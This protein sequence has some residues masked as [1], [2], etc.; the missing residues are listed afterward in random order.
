M[1]KTPL[2][3][4][5][6]FLYALAEYRQ[7]G[8]TSKVVKIVLETYKIKDNREIILETEVPLTHTNEGSSK[9]YFLPD[10]Y[11]MDMF[12][13]NSSASFACN[14]MHCVIYSNQYICFFDQYSG[15][16]LLK[17]NVGNHIST[18]VPEENLFYRLDIA[19]YGTLAKCSVKNFKPKDLGAKK[20]YLPNPPILL[21][22]AKGNFIKQQKERDAS[23]I[24]VEEM[25]QFDI[26]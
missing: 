9:Y 23:K 13:T 16:M 8:A 20:I 18:Y 21:D 11:Q 26:F 24:V 3:Y 10:D 7:Q 12:V 2:F 15:V 5:G 22:Q 14:G 17:E 1:R 25:P 4:D 6:E 19:I